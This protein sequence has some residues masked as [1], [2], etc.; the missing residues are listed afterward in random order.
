MPQLQ[1]WQLVHVVLVS[2]AECECVST[3]DMHLPACKLME[4]CTTLPTAPQGATALVTYKNIL[5]CG[6]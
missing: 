4:S 2:G 3:Q 5:S 1:A 6:T